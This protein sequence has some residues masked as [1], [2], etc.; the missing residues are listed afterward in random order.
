MP[1][2]PAASKSERQNVKRRARNRTAMSKLRTQI[3]KFITAA[4]TGNTETAREELRLT[5]KELDKTA[6]K[7]IIRKRTAA[8]RKSRLTKRLNKLLAGAGEQAPK[9]AEE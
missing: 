4:E 3:K 5:T 7:G 6:A 8:R 1:H 9:T 2:R